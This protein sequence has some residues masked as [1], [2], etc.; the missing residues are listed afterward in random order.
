MSQQSFALPIGGERIT[1]EVVRQQNGKSFL[2][3]IFFDFSS[4]NLIS[5]S[6]FMDLLMLFFDVSV[7]FLLDCVV[8][9]D[10]FVF[11]L[12]FLIYCFDSFF[13]VLLEK[14]LFMRVESGSMVK[15]TILLLTY[16]WSE[17]ISFKQYILFLLFWMWK[18]WKY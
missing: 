5:Y 7:I 14:K 12:F 13:F 8:G 16:Y 17:D 9:F 4:R 18:L 11:I 2:Y 3:L 10:L 1:G 15:T 6:I